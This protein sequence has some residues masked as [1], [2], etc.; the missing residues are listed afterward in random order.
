MMS[1]AAALLLA[2]CPNPGA[3]AGAEGRAGIG[4]PPAQAAMDLNREGKALYREGHFAEARAKYEQ[5]L[6]ADPEFLA[7]SLNRAC[8]FAREEKFLP[9]AQE[10][11][12]LIRRAYVPWGKDVME[13][14][15]LGALQ[16]RPRW[17]TVL[18]STL[19][20]SAPAWGKLVQAGLL[21]V[22]RNQPP[23]K[24]Q[25]QGTLVLGLNQD[26]YA[27]SPQS[28]RFLQVTAEDGRVLAF[29]RSSD[30]RKLVL[31]RAGRLLRT[32][33]QPDLLRGLGVREI[34]LDHMTSGPVVELPG[35][36]REV[37]LWPTTGAAILQVTG[38]LG[39]NG[40]L[41]FDGK[42]LEPAGSGYAR[43]LPGARV[44]RLS[45]RGV[46]SPASEEL[47]LGCAFSVRDEPDPKGV[48]RVRVQPRKGKAFFLDA[49]YGAGLGGLPFPLTE[50]ASKDLLPAGKTR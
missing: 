27:W 21:L 37:S 29:V 28:G 40:L 46:L 4:V 36:V 43:P 10:A 22:A 3:E 47:D 30:G 35:D 33:G 25:G 5:A 44:V 23:V 39:S 42:T 20:E 1:L 17:A 11:T 31:L 50:T 16:I 32:P 48:S 19:V 49:R 18:Q 8:A 14:A 6:L 13:A 15:D 41:R 9:A 26:I 7:P 34:D 38:P 45:N 12:A 24:L 2:V